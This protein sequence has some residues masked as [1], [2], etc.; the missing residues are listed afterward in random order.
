MDISSLR[1]QVESLLQRG[2]GF[3]VSARRVEQVSKAII[4]ICAKRIERDHFFI[5][6]DCLIEIAQYPG[7]IRTDTEY[8]DAT[9][10]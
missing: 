9:R 3:I 7:L 4:R 8:F 2:L 5:K 1:V 6:R 10:F